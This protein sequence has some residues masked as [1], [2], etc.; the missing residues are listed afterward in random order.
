MKSAGIFPGLRRNCHRDSGEMDSLLPPRHDRTVIRLIDRN[1]LSGGPVARNA[2]S[3]SAT[4]W[5]PHPDPPLFSG[6]LP[7]TILRLSYI[8]RRKVGS[9]Q[10]AKRG[11]E[12]VVALDQ[13]PGCL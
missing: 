2:L 13:R 6:R 1:R 7:L 4:P 3:S 12:R 10:H 11:V 5:L 8:S 9:R